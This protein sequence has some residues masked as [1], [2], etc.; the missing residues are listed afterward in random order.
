[1]PTTAS[2]IVYPDSTDHTRLWEHFE[3]LADS[4]ETAIT[5]TWATYAPALV[6]FSLA[7]GAEHRYSR[8]GKTV[9]VQ[10]A[11]LISATGSGPWRVP[12]PLPARTFGGDRALGVW[13]GSRVGVNNYGGTAI[14]TGV[15]SSVMFIISGSPAVVT[16]TAPATWAVNDPISWAVEYETTA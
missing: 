3:A 7:A 13:Q 6:G 1:M 14:L 9:R 15:S 2:G 16:N 12:L 11:G 5:D 8:R 4:T 10:G